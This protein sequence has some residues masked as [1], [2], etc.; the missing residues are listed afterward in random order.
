MLN[1]KLILRNI[2]RI[3]SF[4]VLNILGL[5]IGLSCAMAV[6][7]WVKNELSYDKNL[8][9][10][11]RIYRLTF[12]TNFSGNRMHF[13]RCNEKWIWQMPGVFPQIEELV[14]LA[15]FRHTAIKAGENKFYTNR[16]FATDSNFFKVFNMGLIYGDI[17]N[18][19]KNPYS[20]VI[21]KSLADKCFGNI[22]PIGKTIMISGEYDTELVPFNISGVMN[23]SPALSHIHFD[24]VT[25]F[26]NPSESPDWAYVYLLLK[27]NTKS[28]AILKEF[29]AFMDNVVPEQIREN[30]KPFLQKITDIHLF[31]DKDREL[32][33]NGS[34]TSIYIFILIALVVLL[35]SLVN[36]F[37]LNKA[38]LFA[39]QKQIHIQKIIGSENRSIIIQSLTESVI[40]VVLAFILALFILDISGNPL[41]ILFGVSLLPGGLSELSGLWDLTAIL[42]IISTITGSVPVIFY[43]V[44][45]RKSLISIKSG[46][47]AN[48]HG[49]SSYGLLMT[50]QFCLSILLIAGTVA[51]YMQNRYMFSHSLG[52]MSSDILAFKRQNWEIRNKYSAFRNKALQDPL[53]K[54]VTASMEEPSGETL[55]ALSVESPALIK[56]PEDTRLYVLSVE[57]NFLDF[58]NIPLVAGRNFSKYNPERKGEDYILNES[59]VKKLGWKP[60]EAIGKPFTINFDVPDIFYGGTVVGV[61]RDFNFNTD[62]HEIKPYVLF[63]K[64]IFYLCFLVKVDSARRNEAITHLKKIWE[65]ELP[66]YPFQYE[67]IG[68]LYD[69]A[70]SKE[71]LQSKM[72]GFFSL[73]AMLIICFGLFSIS[74]ILVARRTKEIGIRKVNG[75]KISNVLLL[76]TSGFMKWILI[77]SLIASPIAFYIIDKLQRNFVYRE[78]MHWWLIPAS[79]LLVF[80]IAILTVTLKS[81]RSATR[82]PI[83][84]LRYE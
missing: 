38:R 8:P 64:P 58:F 55:D 18:S 84:A 54:S 23:D 67:F 52:E 12:E 37:N 11:D 83:E 29:P 48:T 19:L 60:E 22:N 75:A 30:Y 39:L 25:S 20:A 74:S 2:F 73:L 71:I 80:I 14:R 15:P 28:A 33:Q 17:E 69:S 44:S 3:K 43:V 31:S 49:L 79:C 47:K 42:L 21:T 10:A 66:D 16:V 68:D 53:I 61:V 4:A 77:S 34:I 7:V 46:T 1:F 63:Q 32:E 5:G 41:K 27:P 59:A 24:I 6:A 76:L 26:K 81:W 57:D 78:E 45:R 40:I 82:N 50:A 13:A 70:Y 9:D 56:G 62:K 36:Y 72:T 65:E 35:I 51:I